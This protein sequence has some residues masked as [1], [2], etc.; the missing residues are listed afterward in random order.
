MFHVFHTSPGGG[1]VE[2]WRGHLRWVVSEWPDQ[3]TIATV[4][5]RGGLGGGDAGD[6]SLCCSGI[7]GKVPDHTCWL[8]LLVRPK[9]ARPQL[10]DP[11]LSLQE[12]GTGFQPPP[13]PTTSRISHFSRLV[14]A[15]EMGWEISRAQLAPGY[16]WCAG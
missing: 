8:F 16:V 12:A 10:G 13:K 5:I 6:H 7:Q 4:L 14:S 3:T 11:H 2:T 9:A 1:K 15:T